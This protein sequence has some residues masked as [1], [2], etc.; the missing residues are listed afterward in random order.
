MRKTFLCVTAILLCCSFVIGQSQYKVLWSFGSTNDGATPLSN[1]IFDHAGNLYGTTSHGGS[2]SACSLSGGCGT[3]FKLS[4]NSDGTWTETILYDFCSKVGNSVCLDGSYPK[5]SLIF[6]AKGNLYGTTSAGGTPPCP[7]GACGT[8][9]ELSPPS[10][11]GGGWVENVL[12]T[13]CVNENSNACPD[14][15]EPN[16][17]LAM[18]ASGNLY[19]TT[20]LGGSGHDTKNNGGGTVFELTHGAGGWAETVLYNFCSL[21]EGKVC[22][23]GTSPQAGL[24]FD[25]VGNLYGTTESGGDFQ[26]N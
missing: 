15:M 20:P 7:I 26:D 18:D 13:F 11:A 1:V 14:G 2:A 24:T 5:A 3:V 25:R 8:V 16:S 21:G 19:G 10:S 6:D 23:D 22:T 9:F 4:P 17:R 12:Y